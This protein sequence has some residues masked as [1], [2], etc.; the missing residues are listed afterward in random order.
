MNSIDPEGIPERPRVLAVDDEEVMGYLIKRVVRHLGY[1]VE[2]VTD[3]DSALKLI[4]KEPFDVILSDFKMPNMTGDQF[5]HRLALLD[6]T[7]LKKLVFITG[8]TVNLKTI[9][10]LEKYSIP[11]L[12][13]P[14]CIEELEKAI[15]NIVNNPNA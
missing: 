12:S 2:W 11:Y 14:F 1:S 15:R 3:C 7:L 6:S 13:K 8:D 10:F 4:E 9:K 5:Y